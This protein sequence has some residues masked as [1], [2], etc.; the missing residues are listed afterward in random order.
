MNPEN[1]TARA[2]DHIYWRPGSGSQDVRP[3]MRKELEAVREKRIKRESGN[4]CW[5]CRKLGICHGALSCKKVRH[6]AE[7]IENFN[8]G[9]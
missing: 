5:D 1:E 9:E 7:R 3:K 6:I 8:Q 4:I 2:I